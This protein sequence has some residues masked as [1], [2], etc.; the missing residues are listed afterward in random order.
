MRHSRARFSGSE[1]SRHKHCSADYI[2][3]TCESEFSVHT[4]KCAGYSSRT[5]RRDHRIKHS[6][7]HVVLLRCMSQVMARTTD[8]SAKQVRVAPGVK[9]DIDARDGL[10]AT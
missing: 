1:A 4:P 2:T 9:A 7:V 3:T 8:R 10:P 6:I 5:R